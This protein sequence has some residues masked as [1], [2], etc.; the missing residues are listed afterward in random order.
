MDLPLDD[1]AC[2]SGLGLGQTRLL[3]QIGRTSYRRER[4]AQ[5]MRQGG[6]ELIFAS[7][8]LAQAPFSACTLECTPGA[9]CDLFDKEHRVTAPR[10]WMRF[11]DC[12]SRNDSI[13]L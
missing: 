5:L 7:V 10:M 8:A 4:V 3:Q 13:R 2:G 6:E 12:E 11:V 9:L 1:V